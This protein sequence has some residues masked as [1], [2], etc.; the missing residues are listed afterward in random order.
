M[1]VD[2]FIRYVFVAF[3]V[4]YKAI[5]TKCSSNTILLSDLF[6]FIAAVNYV[7]SNFKHNRL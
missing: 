5:N 3:S 2:V 7:K 4:N 1:D 6:L